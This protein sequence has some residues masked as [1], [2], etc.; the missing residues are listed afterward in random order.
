MIIGE[1]YYSDCFSVLTVN[2]RKYTF[3]QLLVDM[4]NFHLFEPSC[5]LFLFSALIENDEEKLRFLHVQFQNERLYKSTYITQRG[6]YKQDNFR[7]VCNN[8]NKVKNCHD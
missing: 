5:F 6:D 8:K 1:P 4:F 7:F 3:L 2:K